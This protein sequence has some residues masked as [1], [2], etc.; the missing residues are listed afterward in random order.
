MMIFG[1][2]NLKIV[3]FKFAEMMIFIIALS[4]I[5][6][7][8][9]ENKLI[10]FS[11]ILLSMVMLAYVKTK[12]IWKSTLITIFITIVFWI[13]DCIN[14]I[15]CTYVLHIKIKSIMSNRISYIMYHIATFIVMYIITFITR[16]ILNTKFE[17]ENINYGSKFSVFFSLSLI[18]TFVIFS[19]NVAFSKAYNFSNDIIIMNGIMFMLYFMLLLM[20]FHI[21]SKNIK[22]EAEHKSRKEELERLI[23]YT[24][25]I[26][27]LNEEMREFKHDYINILSSMVGYLESNDIK[28]LKNYFNEKILPIGEDFHKNEYKFGLLKNLKV[29]ELKG[30]ISSKIIRA[31]KKGI[32]V[33]IDITEDIS[34]INMDKL[35]LCRT[36]GV[37]LDN[38]IEAAEQCEKSSIKLGI[39]KKKKAIIIVLM[40]STRE[41]TPPIYKLYEKG[42]STKGQNR[43]LGLSNLRKIIKLYDNV[44]LDTLIENGEFIQK[45]EISNS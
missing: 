8:F 43:G 12:R 13:S 37:L 29:K 38:S 35:D 44:M 11:I 28:A 7:P 1:I 40:N 30:L 21:F 41:D 24:Q 20:I 36:M 2:Y 27:G 26:E 42:F 31:Q 34:D 4:L 3:N 16:K 45:I 25:N 14:I 6:L 15:M 17:E 32:D 5:V 22:M 19:V 39:V 33:F 9:Y 10:V 23:E 18:L